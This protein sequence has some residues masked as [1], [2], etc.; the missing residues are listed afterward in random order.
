M[1]EKQSLLLRE[2][3]PNQQP[4]K[5][6]PPKRGRS[7]FRH[8]IRLLLAFALVHAS[9][10]LCQYSIIE[11][12]PESDA[13]GFSWDK[14]ATTP[15]LEY[16]PCYDGMYCARLKLPLDY[17]NGTTDKTI[18]LAVIK[19]PA[20]VSV[21]DPKYRGPILINPGGPGGSGVE[22]AYR[23]GKHLQAIVQGD[24]PFAKERYFDIV[25]FDPRGIGLTSPPVQC[26]GTAQW[27]KLW[28]LRE[29]EEGTVTSSDAA[30]G[31][32]WSMMQAA[33]GK[34]SK[35]EDDNIQHFLTTASVARDMLE[36]TEASARWRARELKKLGSSILV[37][38]KKANLLYWGFSYGS[39]LGNSYAALFPDRIERLIVD[40]VVDA[41]DYVAV[42]WIDDLRDTE[43]VMDLFYYHCARVGYPT[44]PLADEKKPTAAKVQARTKDILKKMWHSPIPILEPYADV[45]S[46][47]DIRGLIFASLYSPITSFPY[48]ANVLA[49]L[50]KGDG[51][52]LA[53]LMS[54]YHTVSCPA[55]ESGAQTKDAI[56]L[57]N[58]S[59]TFSSKDPFTG[60]AI[61]CADGYSITDM[62][63]DQFADKVKTIMELSPTLGDMWS[64][65]AL[66]CIGYTLRPGYAFR[67]PWVGKTSHPLLMI[68]NTAD[69]VTP[70]W[71]AKK[72]ARG[73]EGAR[74]LTQNSP[75]H[76]SLAAYSPCTFDYIH[77]YF[78]DGTLPAEGTVCE[79]E[80]RPWGGKDSG[81][82]MTE[83]VKV[84]AD[85]HAQVMKGLLASGGGHRFGQGFGRVDAGKL[86][87]VV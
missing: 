64:G 20:T 66:P 34:C 57:R 53:E 69:P 51:T 87:A 24:F 52:L 54:T 48:L 82:V 68:G 76:C 61:A 37:E 25:G 83:E 5:Q 46:W 1:D 49:Q 59:A 11:Y 16:A 22:L 39:Y 3:L 63:R 42:D 56:P 79:V 67:G 35:V 55:S 26:S 85:M 75:G 45:V 15:E 47:S 84:K 71:S 81:T 86:L 30:L 78:F 28:I 44:C 77:K 58:S 12:R 36:L 4:C 50:E 62:T 72:M 19:I 80:T 2:E 14:I 27:A 23:A 31:R 33:S 18:S 43:T 38:P 73:F 9:I 8:I 6:A 10:R 29:L 65:I 7:I 17:W 32:L 21:D 13:N 60:S 70:L 40:G 41:D 74:V